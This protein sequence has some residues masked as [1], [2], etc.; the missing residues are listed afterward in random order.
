MIDDPPGSGD[1]GTRS[2]SG[3]PRADTATIVLVGVVILFALFNSRS[4]KITW[5]VASSRAPLFVVI[6]L[7]VAVGF[8]AGYLTAQRRGK[9]TD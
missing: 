2:G 3:F 4:T 9:R 7:C 1:A 6:A 5:I 8:A